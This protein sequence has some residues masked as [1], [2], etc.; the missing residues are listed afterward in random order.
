MSNTDNNG[1]KTEKKIFN[2]SSGTGVL[3]SLIFGA[4]MLL[5]MVMLSRFMH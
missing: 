1:N 5:F 3:S 2:E 4:I